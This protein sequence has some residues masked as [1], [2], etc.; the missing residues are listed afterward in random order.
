M[1]SWPM[2]KSKNFVEAS[3][4]LHQR[5]LIPCSFSFLGVDFAAIINLFSVKN[6][7]AI[8]PFANLK[9]S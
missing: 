5:V 6:F 4:L 9:S 8:N 2:K 1:P 7:K 3:V